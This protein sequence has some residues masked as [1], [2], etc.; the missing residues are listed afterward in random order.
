MGN[1]K[2]TKEELERYDSQF[3]EKK[4]EGKLARFAKKA[5]LNT[6]YYVLLLWEVLKS[7]KIADK[8]AVTAALGYFISPIDLI[9]DV[10]L[11]TGFVDDASVLL[12][13]LG[14]VAASITSAMKSGAKNQLHKWFDFKDSEL[15][16]KYR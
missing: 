10:I 11:G 15:N 16:E 14:V 5:G 1:N 8:L 13:A 6:V 2:F 7:G 12:A 4:L 3:D 9:P